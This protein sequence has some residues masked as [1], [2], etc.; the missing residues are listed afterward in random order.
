MN[1]SFYIIV[2]LVMALVTSFAQS[3][4]IDNTA[5]GT[6]YVPLDMIVDGLY[7]N[8]DVP[9]Y[10]LT[11]LDEE[12]F[13]YYSFLSYNEDLFAV[14]ADALVR[15]E[16]HSMVLIRTD[17][18]NGP[19]LAYQIFRNADPNKW[20]SVG[21]EVVYV[22]YTYHY[23]VLV[24]SSQDRA[25]AIIGNFRDMARELDNMDMS[26]LA[27]RNPRFEGDVWETDPAGYGLSPAA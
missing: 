2:A 17:A 3:R 21:S 15:I 16:P 1:S 25:D 6:D 11:T 20:V 18:G 14:A 19:E 22:A 10:A 4:G 26:L 13:K 9:P 24:M 7:E 8:V 5:M 23:V 27:A 12:N